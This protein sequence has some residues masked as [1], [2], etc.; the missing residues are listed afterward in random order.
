MASTRADRQ[1]PVVCAYETVVLR[2]RIV[3]TQMHV[4][5]RNCSSA[6]SVPMKQALGT[7]IPVVSAGE[8]AGVRA[9]RAQGSGL[10]DPGL[11]DQSMPWPVTPG[12]APLAGSLILDAW[13]PDPGTHV[14]PRISRSKTPPAVA[15]VSHVPCSTIRPCS[16][17]M[18]RSASRIVE[19][20]WAMT[21]VVR[22]R[23]ALWSACWTSRSETA[24][25]CDVASSRMRMLGLRMTARGRWRCAVADRPRPSRRARRRAY[26]AHR[27]GCSRR[28]TGGRRRSRGRAR[29][30]RRPHSR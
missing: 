24:S 29:L 17:T 22:P 5:A 21:M 7:P 26:P 30:R 16:R 12:R 2:H 23:D 8:T 13:I 18:S 9:Q 14:N 11:R 10:R 20:R 27:A 25:R 6:L 19:R 15:S 4:S 28:R 1:R 3:R